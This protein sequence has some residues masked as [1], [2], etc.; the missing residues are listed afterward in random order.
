MT[1]K[2]EAGLNKIGNV[3][4]RRRLARDIT[5]EIGVLGPIHERGKRA[6]A[7]HVRSCVRLAYSWESNFK[8]VTLAIVEAPITI[9]GFFS[10]RLIQAGSVQLNTQIEEPLNCR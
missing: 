8:L 3:L 6:I 5:P 4:G 7:D 2:A 1:S 10:G 9:S